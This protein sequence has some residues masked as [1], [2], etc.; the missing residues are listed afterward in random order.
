MGNGFPDIF[1]ISIVPFN[2]T[3]IS[4]VQ[5]LNWALVEGLHPKW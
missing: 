3:S 5:K 4:V 2:I 1:I